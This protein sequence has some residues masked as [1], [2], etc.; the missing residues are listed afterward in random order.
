MVGI[1]NGFA[2]V[3]SVPRWAVVLTPFGGDGCRNP[4]SRLMATLFLELGS[5]VVVFDRGLLL[6]LVC[7]LAESGEGVAVHGSEIGSGH[8]GESAC[9]YMRLATEPLDRC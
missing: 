1:G 4:I 8:G 9:F 3:G 6:A 5:E 2:V 7:I